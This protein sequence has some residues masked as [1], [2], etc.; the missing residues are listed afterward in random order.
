[1]IEISALPGRIRFRVPH[2]LSKEVANYIH[3]SIE[4]LRGVK[5]SKVNHYT[6]SILVVYN[7]KHLNKQTIEFEINNILDYRNH[8]KENHLL[9]Q[10][11]VY[12]SA[13]RNRDRSRNRLLFYG[14]LYGLF[15]FKTYLFGQFSISRN[16]RLL[17]VASAITIIEGYP[18]L[19]RFLS[20]L[21]IKSP[22]L[23]DFLLK[24]TAMALIFL[25]ED[26]TGCFLL[27]LKYLN[28][29]LRYSTEVEYLRMI[30]QSI[31]KNS[32]MVRLESTDGI[33]LLT[34]ISSLEIGDVVSLREGDYIPANGIITTGTAAIDELFASGYVDIKNKVVNDRLH[35][36]S[37]VLSGEITMK[38]LE[39][40]FSAEKIQNSIEQLLIHE[41]VTSYEE[42]IG[43]FSFIMAFIKY[44]TTGDILSS[45]SI[46][47]LLCPTGSRLAVNAGVN[48]YHHLLGKHD[49]FLR[50]PGTLEK[51]SQLNHVAFDKTGTLTQGASHTVREDAPKLIQSLKEMGV[52]KLSLIS[53]DSK[54]K[55]LSIGKELN[56]DNI[57]SNCSMQEKGIVINMLKD[58]DTIMMVGDGVN[59]LLAMEYADVSVGLVHT[60]CD[61]VKLHTDYVLFDNDLEKIADLIVL[62]QR[63]YGTI[64][65]TINF[66]KYYNIALGVL[67]LFIPFNPY[68]AKTLNTINSM[69]VMLLSKRIEYYKP[70]SKP[71]TVN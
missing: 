24:I 40:P 3:V 47:L 42:S 21:P 9:K 51:M 29:Y 4:R 15:K 16:I 14:S 52:T 10:E 2:L 13:V 60:S 35:E 70:N 36:G 49:I 48:S 41:K 54:E 25:R 71:Q 59:D 69:S 56:I 45:M 12:I 67:S 53:G 6:S 32:N 22:V 23:S 66:S 11:E 43:Y 57:Y 18:T 37:K 33:E 46:M 19:K 5:Y 58:Q 68:Y 1:M 34:P 44:F 31:D 8:Y 55:T 7:S 65:H 39:I 30:N 26:A 61:K 20:N 38:V 17:T 62:S 50:N 27:S 64:N 28:D 63:S